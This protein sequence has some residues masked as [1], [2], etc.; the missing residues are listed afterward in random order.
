MKLSI[1]KELALEMIYVMVSTVY[2]TKLH[3]LNEILLRMGLD[4]RPAELVLFEGSKPVKY[5][6]IA[7]LL[8]LAGAALIGRKYRHMR[9]DALDFA[10]ALMSIIAII[11]VVVIIILLWIFIDNPIARAVLSIGFVGIV[12]A[13]SN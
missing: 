10:E 8:G 12:L 7:I 3:F 11:I 1:V 5:F 4:H 6:L 2:L 9:Y 13:K